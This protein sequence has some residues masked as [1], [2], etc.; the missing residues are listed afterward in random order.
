MELAFSFDWGL[1]QNKLHLEKVKEFVAKAKKDGV[2]LLS[3]WW[4]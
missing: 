3:G 1:L 2:S 4:L